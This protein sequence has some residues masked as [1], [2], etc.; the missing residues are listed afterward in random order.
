MRTKHPQPPGE[1]K[2]RRIAFLLVPG[3]ALL[4]YSCAMEPYRAANTLAGR[5]LYRWQHVSPDG[6]PV[7]ASNGVAI[8]PDQGIDRSIDAEDLFVCAGGNPTLFDDTASLA[9]LRAHAHRGARIGGVAGGPVV[10]AR[11]GLLHGRRCTMHWEYI[12]AFVENFPRQAVTMSRFEIDRGC[13][14]SAGGMAAFEMMVALIEEQHGR[15]LASAISEWFL[16]IHPPSSDEPQRMSLRE[17]YGIHHPGL[18]AV[19]AHMEAALEEP[20]EREALAELAGISVRQLE[21]LFK[22]H[23]GAPIARH[24]LNLRL[25]RARLLLRQ[26]TWGVLEVAISCGFMSAAHFSRAYRMRFGY[27]PRRERNRFI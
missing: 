13:C 1:D 3:F 17:R 4:S 5:E 12:P 8:V 9:W 27:A 6:R 23:L 2:P 11:A 24:Y 10:L 18:L 16:L 14:T 15:E 21:R 7:L 26:T 25:D 19:L 20:M 22:T